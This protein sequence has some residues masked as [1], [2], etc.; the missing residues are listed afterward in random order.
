MAE[1]A[2]SV[3]AFLREAAARSLY[4]QALD[5][6]ARGER[7][8]AVELYRRALHHHPAM[9][10]A[11]CNLGALL[12]DLG[13]LEEA[14]RHYRDALRVVPD[15]RDLLTNLGCALR[16]AGRPAE[17]EEVFLKLLASDP[18]DA[19]A[20]LDLAMLLLQRGEWKAGWS[21]YEWRWAVPGAASG[22]HRLP[23]WD[24]APRPEATLRLFAEQGYGDTL[25]FLRYLPLAAE[26]VGEVVLETLPGLESLRIP[27]PGG[28]LRVV[29]RGESLPPAELQAPLMSLPHRLAMADPA[30][31]PAPPYL[32]PPPSRRPHWHR[33]VTSL[34]GIRVGLVWG[35]TPKPG[36]DPWSDPACPAEHLSKL[37]GIPGITFV[38]LQKRPDEAGE[39]LLRQ[40]LGLRSPGGPLNDFAD[41]AAVIEA[42][43]LV[44][45]VD[46]AVAHLAGA[47]GRPVWILLPWASDWRWGVEGETTPWYP[48][49][50]LFRQPHPGEW[51]P[52][53]A[54]VAEAL[55]RF[56]QGP[57]PP[58]FEEA[59]AVQRAGDGRGAERL[60]AHLLASDPRQEAAWANLALLRAKENVGQGVATLREGLGHLPSSPLLHHR[61]GGMLLEAGRQA[62]AVESLEEAVRL[63]PDDAT[64]HA[65]LA[66]ARHRAGRLEEALE[67]AGRALA[68]DPRQPEALNLH[69]IVLRRLGRPEEAVASFRSLLEI[70][71]QNPRWLNNLAIA[72]QAAGRLDEALRIFDWLHEQAP[73]FAEGRWNR[74]CALL[75]AG[76]EEGWREY[77]WGFVAGHRSLPPLPGRQWEEG[78]PVP[79]RLLVVAEQ[80]IGDTLHFCRLLPRLRRRGC[81]VTLA[82]P[83]TLR[84]LLEA[85]GVADRVVSLEE[86]TDLTVE[87]HVALLSLPA[88][89]GCEPPWE[90]PYLR[91]PRDA[92][93]SP[94]PASRGNE[95]ELR[96]GLVWRGNPDH[97]DD[98]L[99]SI[100]ATEMARLGRPGGVRWFTLQPGSPE[101]VELLQERIGLEDA[102]V[103]LADFAAT[104]V[105]CS[106][107]DLIVT[108]DTAVAH[109]AAAL[110]LPVWLLLPF[111]PDWRWG[112]AGESTP[113]YPSMRI[114]RQQ[115]PG[116]WRGVLERVRRALEERAAEA[117]GRPALPGKGGGSTPLSDEGEAPDPD[118]RLERAHRLLGE[119]NLGEAERLYRELLEEEGER[120]EARNGL[121]ILLRLRG[122]VEAARS[123]FEEVLA[124]RPDHWRAHFNRAQLL[125]LEGRWLEGW[126]EYEWRLATRPDLFQGT[127]PLWDGSHPGGRV[128]RVEVEQGAGDTFQ[129]VHLLSRLR[130]MGATVE[131]AC[132]R[133][134]HPLMEASGVADRLLEPGEESAAQWR[135][136]LL[137]LP[138]RFGLDPDREWPLTPW[139]SP[140]PESAARWRRRLRGAFPA[141]GLVWAGSREHQEDRRR[142]C[143]PRELAPLRE[144]EGVRWYS[145]QVPDRLPRPWP[146]L[147]S[148]AG[149]LTDWQETAAVVTALDLVITVDTAVAHLAGA[150]GRPVWLLLPWAAEWRWGVEGSAVRWYPSMRLFRQPAP[151]AWASVV[152]AVV[153]ALDV[154]KRESGGGPSRDGTRG[155]SPRSLPAGGE[156]TGEV[157][158]SWQEAARLLREGDGEGARQLFL[159]VVEA[160]PGAVEGW[161]GLAAAAEACN[162]VAVAVSAW[163]NVLAITPG[164]GDARFRLALALFAA[165]EVGEARNALRDLMGQQPDHHQ[166]RI[167]LAQWLAEG[168]EGEAADALLEEGLS[169]FPG[170]RSLLAERGRRY[171]AAGCWEKA[172]RRIREALDAAG[173]R[174]EEAV[175][176]V[177][178]GIALQHQGREEEAERQYRAALAI[179]ALPGAWTN[180]G[181]LALRRNDVNGAL[182]CFDR[183]LTI[184][185]EDADAR[186][187]RSLALLLAGDLEAGW[188]EYEWRLRRPCSG[189]IEPPGERWRGEPL[190]GRR[191]LVYAEQGYGDT[192]QYCRFLRLAKE[193]GGEVVFRCQPGLGAVLQ[194][195]EGVDELIDWAEQ[196]DRT[197]PYHFHLP[198]MSLP[199]VLEL[200]GDA[201][202]GEIPYLH[203]DPLRVNAWRERLGK[204]GFKVGLVWAGRPTH[205]NDRNRSA[206]LEVFE[207]L[208][209]L[210]EVRLFSLQKGE[211]AGRLQQVEWARDRVVDLG[212]SLEC[213]SE[214]AALLEVLDL[215]V[216][217]DTAVAH[218]AG[219]LGR[220]CWLL[221]PFAPDWRWQLQRE[222]SPWYPTLRLFRQARPGDWEGVVREVFRRLGK[223]IPPVR[224]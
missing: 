189:V 173:E 15:Q 33:R 85:S 164:D 132:P 114:F 14:I 20:H 128:V 82:A 5:R 24:G 205:Q 93:V 138:L 163:H 203:A 102:G 77:E 166:G 178:L 139:L 43:D 144:V 219:A 32:A 1:A 190:A 65:D 123:C 125:L 175:L 91:T 83:A 88:R 119:G 185:P 95:G 75:L 100:P 107:M 90:F 221:L 21:E 169:L 158:R 181:T 212:T 48:Q 208:G 217:V 146:E 192:F 68:L 18:S 45:T 7:R 26:R 179:E 23:E 25:Q 13:E 89:I 52:V 104:A 97:H 121:G 122:E 105:L 177:D 72:L 180:L 40:R 80:G 92:A 2:G 155:E 174:G 36:I 161:R 154:W 28:R 168:D 184:D 58:S 74:A 206:P 22:R 150:L 62:E 9:L 57:L 156:G 157:E 54:A 142:S 145:L 8:E 37:G 110:A 44:I 81:R 35:G 141:V 113:W 30:D 67:S 47:L 4:N 135:V 182:A 116:D 198:L 46:T 131:L 76:R 106:Q 167:R 186:F 223:G 183:A 202:P 133:V 207:P 109:L 50:R 17:A 148:L 31:A 151:D 108:V 210:P 201:L 162:D 71:S 12:H 197:I 215:V 101:G 34:P 213:F 84:G 3:R 160:M 42:L 56:G 147:E 129:F 188:R 55:G 136:P 69:G 134:F 111:S 73:E 16:T 200:D 130:R 127:P 196:P 41:T 126:R 70:D 224:Q 27:D 29:A 211:A 87:R 94:L 59:L 6:A 195:L 118:G 96:V 112:R 38:S 171:L 124:L 49:A 191:L 153:G 98:R 199:A 86:A 152:E 137:S 143:P 140:G 222:D 11:H 64:L 10:E 66:V 79:R 172:E 194:G 170:V 120:V 165:G 19:R 220:P 61:L 218:L 103:G 117:A 39:R 187:N 53:I 60:Y 51:P 216:T 214:T 204:E 193:R 99:R 149:H 209:A 78:E 176:H 115:R 63:R 159:K